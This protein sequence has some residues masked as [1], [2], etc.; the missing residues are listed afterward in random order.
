MQTR[1]ESPVRIYEVF[2][3][4]YINGSYYDRDTDIWFPMQWDING[5]YAGKPSSADL[6]NIKVSKT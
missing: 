3:G 1:G 5:F 6:V 4:R 2:D